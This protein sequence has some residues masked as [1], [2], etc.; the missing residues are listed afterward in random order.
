MPGRTWIIAPDR[1]TLL[2]RWEKL[3]TAK[4]PGQ[5]DELF[6]PHIRDGELGDRFSA[7]EITD[8]LHGF[9]VRPSSVFDDKEPCNAPIR[10][11]YRSFDRQWIIP[12][13]RLINQANP[14]LW[15]LMSQKQVFL[16][17]LSRTSPLSG[18]A[19]TASS[20]LP[21]I[22]HYKGSFGGRVFP[23]WSD[24]KAMQPNIKPALL[25]FLHETLGKPVGPEDL[26]SYVASVGANPAYTARFQA[27]LSTPGL[28]IPLTA[29]PLLF[30]EAV[31]LG[32]R[33]LWLHTFGERFTDPAANR[34]A[35]PPR[36]QV[37]PPTV[38]LTGRIPSEPENFPDTLDY[39]AAKCRLLVGHGYIENVRPSVWAYGISG[40]HVLSQWFSYR[41]KS[42]ERPVIG[43]RRPP[44]KLNDIQPDHWLPEYTAELLNVLNVLT[45]LVE[46]EPA[47]AD[48]LERICAGPLLSNDTLSAAGALAL[49]PKQEK[50]KK[51][52]SKH[53]K[54]F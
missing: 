35:G 4:T 38:P 34:P 53:P 22:D 41:R 47:Q 30:Q 24:E 28:R 42:R 21:D 49:P 15:E 20:L 54:L 37:S 40:K 50:L 16:T 9:P 7:K 46:L 12:D 31:G 19:L 32:R 13:K 29:D 27:D 36:V 10:F 45:L 44:S 25:K 43:D 2:K 6:T 8:A 11:A 23:L 18:P 5:M 48:L 39:D 33:I 3:K 26:L 14:K 51:A 1:E 52:K 17:A